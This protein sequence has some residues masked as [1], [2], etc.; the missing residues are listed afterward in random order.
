[1][2]IQIYLILVLEKCC[3]SIHFKGFARTRTAKRK[4]QSHTNSAVSRQVYA[5]A[6]L[7]QHLSSAFF[8]HMVWYGP[9][10]EDA[11]KLI[12]IYQFYRAEEDNQ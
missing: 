7:V 4:S 10:L 3:W 5:R 1:V 9:M 6:L 8:K 2:G 11:E 12:K